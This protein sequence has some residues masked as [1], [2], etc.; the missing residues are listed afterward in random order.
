MEHWAG[1]FHEHM[2][3]LLDHLGEGAIV[4]LD[5]QAG[6]VLTARLEM[7]A[8]HYE[9]RRL[10]ARI[11]DGETP[12][13]PAP[14]GRLYLDREGWDAMLEES[15]LAIFS[16]FNKPE[17][18]GGVDAGGRQGRLFMDVRQA[19]ENVFRAYAAHAETQAS[20][21]RKNV[22][23]AWSRGS[24]ERLRHMLTENR[25]A[26]EIVTDAYAVHRLT[27]GV[28][29]VALLGL[30][31]GFITDDLAVCAEQ[32]LLGER[33]ARPPRRKKRADQF[34]AD[35]TGIEV[36]DL[37]VHQDHGIGRYDGLETLPVSGA[38]HDC[39]KM[40]YLGDDKLFVPVENIEV[41][42][43]FGSEGA[44]VALETSEGAAEVLP[45]AVARALPEGA[46]VVAPTI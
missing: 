7:I 18:A 16:P 28:V 22:V 11:A 12:Y 24:A 31:R 27:P 13:R 39:L 36:G 42:S 44:G 30:E 45:A 32:D 37:L 41:L 1:L 29:G 4:S 14:P 33:I 15:Q 8:D 35:A 10:P 17:G 2:E 20:R 43:R 9:A 19:G 34:I 46:R 21:G 26:A 23:A 40:L 5:H 25:V 38:P 6:D 3:S